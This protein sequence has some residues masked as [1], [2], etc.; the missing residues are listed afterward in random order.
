MLAL[1]STVNKVVKRIEVHVGSDVVECDSR[2]SV[3]LMDS[4]DLMKRFTM[5]AVMSAPYATDTF[6][7]IRFV[8]DTVL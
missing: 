1:F 2:V 7:V 3:D 4:F 8:Y 5:Q 6:F